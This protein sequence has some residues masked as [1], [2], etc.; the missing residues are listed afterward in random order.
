MRNIIAVILC[1]C[2][3]LPLSDC[4]NKEQPKQKAEPKTKVTI[5]LAENNSV[6]GYRV[7]N[8]KTDD[9]EISGDKIVVQTPNTEPDTD[10][11]TQSIQYCGNLNS[12]TFHLSTCSSVKRMHDDNKYFTSDRNSLTEQGFKPCKSCNP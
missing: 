8:P 5:N 1:F 4:K 2:L 3:L 6:N 10:I 9:T 7:S 11:D 12:K